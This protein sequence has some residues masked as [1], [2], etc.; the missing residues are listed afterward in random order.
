[1][2]SVR[3]P[4]KPTVVTIQ[5]SHDGLWFSKADSSFPVL[6]CTL[7]C[8]FCHK[9]SQV[10][11]HTLSNL[12]SWGSSDVQPLLIGG[13]IPGVQTVQLL[14]LL[15]KLHFLAH[16]VSRGW[17]KVS[18]SPGW[19]SSYYVAQ[20]DLEFGNL[21]SSLLQPSA[22][23]KGMQHASFSHTF[24]QTEIGFRGVVFNDWLD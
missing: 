4:C 20:D 17:G 9:H 11:T 8:L 7:T 10:P 23:V 3:S 2:A 21:K 14:L 13:H 1:M 19:P 12:C 16:F 15:P 24:K 6:L 5:A 18:C 22:G